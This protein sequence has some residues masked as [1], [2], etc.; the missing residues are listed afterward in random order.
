MLFYTM[1]G[2]PCDVCNE[3]ID[4]ARQQSVS[5]FV[6]VEKHLL[7]GVLVPA[8]YPFSH[9]F[10]T[11]Y[12]LTA[13]ISLLLLLAEA[14]YVAGR[15]AFSHKQPPFPEKPAAYNLAKVRVLSAVLHIIR[16]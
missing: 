5:E 10:I 8:G 16:E 11:S 7:E 2:M 1:F 6:Q 9:S 3:G 14:P 13:V 15:H 12:A 4:C